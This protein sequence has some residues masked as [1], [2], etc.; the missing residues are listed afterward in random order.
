MGRTPTGTWLGGLVED[1]RLALPGNS[2]GL[3]NSGVCVNCGSSL[4][5][6]AVGSKE[7][8][9]TASRSVPLR[10]DGRFSDT[11]VGV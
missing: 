11:G 10:A 3:E 6:D 1:G 8:V 4:D 9:I 2:I 5:N 7:G